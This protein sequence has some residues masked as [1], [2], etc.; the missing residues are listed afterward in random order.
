MGSVLTESVACPVCNGTKQVDG[1]DCTNCGGQKQFG[2]PTGKTF[3][4]ED[5]TPCVHTYRIH[6]GKPGAYATKATL[7][8]LY[9]PDTYE[10]DSGD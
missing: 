2:R 1:A 4:R 5:G 6:H 8:C 3:K 10:V 7:S 9:C